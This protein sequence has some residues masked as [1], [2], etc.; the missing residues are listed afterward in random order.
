MNASIGTPETIVQLAKA[1]LTPGTLFCGAD[2]TEVSTVLGS[3]VAVCLIDRYNRAGGM[4]HFVLPYDPAGSDNIRYG[5]AAL[6]RLR[7]GMSLLGCPTRD[8][9]A[10]V[11]G[12]A[13]VLPF[14]EARDT[15]GAQNV[16]TAISWLQ[17]HLIPIQARRTGGTHGLLIRFY[18]ASGG[19]LVRPIN[20]G[21]GI[22]TVR[23]AQLRSWGPALT[24]EEEV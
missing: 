5:D 8:L 19:V 16:R 2:P 14:G 18:T 12:G 17:G 4:N 24:V 11:F 6:E 10:K 7:E 13:N 20:P 3:C 1:Y 9:R 21:S 15:V 23:P 22:D